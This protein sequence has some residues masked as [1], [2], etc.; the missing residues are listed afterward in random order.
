MIDN[1]YERP[2][3]IFHCLIKEGGKNLWIYHT[4]Q[5]RYKDLVIGDDSGNTITFPTEMGLSLIETITRHLRT[6]YQEEK[7]NIFERVEPCQESA[8]FCSSEP[9][10]EYDRLVILPSVDHN[11]ERRFIYNI[12]TNRIRY[13]PKE[14]EEQQEGSNA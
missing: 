8:I 11:G 14:N 7:H 1:M 3:L 10:P 6:P 2:G 4:E 5:P 13:I 9:D 12:K